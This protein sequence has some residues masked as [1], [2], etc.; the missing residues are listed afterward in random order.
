[1]LEMDW[2]PW[3][4]TMQAIQLRQSVR[5]AE[6]AV[7]CK[8][9]ARPAP[10]FGMRQILLLLL[11]PPISS[12]S[13]SFESSGRMQSQCRPLSLAASSSVLVVQ[14]AARRSLVQQCRPQQARTR[15]RLAT[16]APSQR[17]CLW[18]PA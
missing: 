3:L 11:V 7:P 9:P 13:D 17:R 4:K 8:S 2:R 6:G 16:L 1:M 10:I 15:P 5:P 14:R 12:Q 18:L